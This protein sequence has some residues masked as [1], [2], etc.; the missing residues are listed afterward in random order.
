MIHSLRTLQG[1]RIQLFYLLVFVTSIQSIPIHEINVAL[2][3]QQRYFFLLPLY[4]RAKIQRCTLTLAKV[5]TFQSILSLARKFK[6]VCLL[7]NCKSLGILARKFKLKYFSL[8]PV[9]PFYL[10]AKIQS[11]VFFPNPNLSSHIFVPFS[12]QKYFFMKHNL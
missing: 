12:C 1:M 3:V 11:C 10:G 2:V 5:P 6:Y 4:R 9:P 8:K 7:S